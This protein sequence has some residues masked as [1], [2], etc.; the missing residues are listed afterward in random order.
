MAEDKVRARQYQYAANSN[1]VLQAD[2]EGGSRAREPTGEVRSHLLSPAD[3]WQC[4]VFPVC[5]CVLCVF[6]VCLRVFVCVYCMCMFVLK[7]C[8]SVWAEGEAAAVVLCVYNCEGATERRMRL[9]LLH[10]LKLHCCVYS[11]AVGM[12]VNVHSA[13]SCHCTNLAKNYP[14]FV[15]RWHVLVVEFGVFFFV[16]VCVCC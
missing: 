13:A 14:G 8:V 16:C 15:R 7:V 5:V 11:L 6:C 10:A 12:C 9:C 2:R 1:L 4:A 3:A